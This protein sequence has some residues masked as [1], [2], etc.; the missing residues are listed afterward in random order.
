MRGLPVEER[1]V[2]IVGGGV[3][4]VEALITLA[5][6]GDDRL[7]V[8]LV[9]NHPTFVLPPEQLGIPWGE[10]PLSIDLARLCRAFGAE[11]AL[12]EV[13]GVDAAAHEV[14]TTSGEALT[15]ERLLLCPGARPRAPY[16]ARTRT[17]GF[18]ALPDVLA[19]APSV[20]VAVVVPEGVSWTLPAYELALRCARRGRDVRVVTSER[21]VLEAFGSGVTDAVRAL[22][23]RHG[24][25]AHTGRAPA[26]GDRIEGL[27]GTVITL[28]L[29]DGPALEGL[30]ADSRGF[31]RVDAKQAV[32]GAEHVWAAGDVTDG[33][34]KQGGLAAQQ[35]ELAASEAVRSCGGRPPRGGPPAIL[36]GKLTTN[37][38]EELYLRRTLDG[39]DDG[40]SLE[41][42]LWRP[43]SAICAWRLARW[44]DAHR[45][46]LRSSPL[47]PR[48]RTP[49]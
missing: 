38:G 44:L 34:V 18:G 27:A 25:V 24:V 29:Q 30:D 45:D 31:L 9:A 22:L 19:E 7:R 47:A 35:A 4:G 14:H 11:F 48:L 6:L 21:T 46:E 49:V 28:P 32:R 15:Y 5:D 40:R 17:L 20:S 1:E 43:P 33:P 2:L 37:D 36:R 23:E 42:P 41:R 26:P 3:A 39:A 16:G 8:R 12:A 13:T 10:T